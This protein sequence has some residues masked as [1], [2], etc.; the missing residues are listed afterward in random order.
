MKKSYAFFITALA[1]LFL[2]DVPAF[3]QERVLRMDVT[4]RVETDASLTVTE[5]ISFIAE[6]MEI[7]R[8]LI[9]DIPVVHR[10]SR[11]R[12]SRRFWKATP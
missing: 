9:R 10:E 2:P 8:G 11:H 5:R 7:R 6:S 4:A 1:F 12:G 3:G